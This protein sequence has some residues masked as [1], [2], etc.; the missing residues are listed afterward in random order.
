[1]SDEHKMKGEGFTLCKICEKGDGISGTVRTFKTNYGFR[2]H[3]LN[4]HGLVE[5]DGQLR[6]ARPRRNPIR[7][8][9][10]KKVEAAVVTE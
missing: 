7:Q 4:V 5:R 1:M 3:L 6:K 2:Q 9:K 10:A 8:P